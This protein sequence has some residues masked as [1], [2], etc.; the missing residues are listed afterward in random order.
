[1]ENPRSLILKNLIAIILGMLFIG[2]PSYQE[3][4]HMLNLFTGG[5]VVLSLYHAWRFGVKHY[6][7]NNFSL[8]L[9]WLLPF[10]IVFAIF[11]SIIVGFLIS[12]PQF[13][14][15]VYLMGKHTPARSSP[16][17]KV[18]NVIFFNAKAPR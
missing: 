15:G 2:L 14:Y 4:H 8:L 5:Y 9:I 3:T 1:M 6:T 16:P 13:A 11:V 12:I 18:N 17:P 7:V 10:S